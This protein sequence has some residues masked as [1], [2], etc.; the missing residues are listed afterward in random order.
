MNNSCDNIKKIKVS[1]LGE[2]YYLKSDES[3]SMILS[4]ADL[5]S[6]NIKEICDKYPEIDFTKVSTLVAIQMATN[7]LK[8]K[9]LIDNFKEYSDNLSNNIDFEVSKLDNNIKNI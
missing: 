2:D 4:A 1:I 5:V 8:S 3:E 9:N 7:L 6:K